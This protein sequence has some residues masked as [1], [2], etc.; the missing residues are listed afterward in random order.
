MKL[1]QYTE[2]IIR[3]TLP[4]LL[5]KEQKKLSTGRENCITSR[6]LHA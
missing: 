3:N 2:Q 4:E 5:E 6:K 1:I